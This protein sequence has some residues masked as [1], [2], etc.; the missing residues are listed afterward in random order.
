MTD[1][2]SLVLTPDSLE[3]FQSA[4]MY[5]HVRR[6]AKERDHYMSRWTNLTMNEIG[7]NETVERSQ[8]KQVPPRI[9]SNSYNSSASVGFENNHLAVELADWKARLRKQRQEL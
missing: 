4:T 6:L 9:V 1:N 7:S 2:Q 5:N 8:T 3:F